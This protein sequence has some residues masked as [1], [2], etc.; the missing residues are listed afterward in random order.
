MAEALRIQPRTRIFHSDCDALRFTF[1]SADQH[2]SRPIV[3]PAHGFHGIDNQIEDHLLQLYSISQDERHI[4]RKLSLQGHVIPF[5]F[6]ARQGDN[7]HYDFVDVQPVLSWW[8]F[9]CQGA[10]PAD[11]FSGPTGISDDELDRLP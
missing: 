4:T 9:L 5:D 8:R 10:N 2:L 6:T 1:S 11:D 7:L 3:R